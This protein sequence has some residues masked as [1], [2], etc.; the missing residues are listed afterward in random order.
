MYS[1]MSTRMSAEGSAKR[2]LARAR[3]SS[4]LPTPVGPEKMNEP[5][6]RF[7]SLSPAR[8][9]RMARELIDF[10]RL[11]WNDACLSF[12]ESS[13]PVRTASVVQVRKP[14][15]SSSVGRF[16]RYGGALQPLI[17]ALGYTDDAGTR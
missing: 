2:N 14:V 7:G 12:H 16:R 9:R 17:D 10:V 4:V 6:G 13:R 1:D 15:Y 8:E 5:M 3:A 11:P